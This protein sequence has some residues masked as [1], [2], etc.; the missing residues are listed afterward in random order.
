MLWRVICAHAHMVHAHVHVRTCVMYKSAHA[1]CHVLYRYS[2]LHALCFVARGPAR[3]VCVTSCTIIIKKK[4]NDSKLS[5]ETTLTRHVQATAPVGYTF[6]F[7]YREA[8][9]PMT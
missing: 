9:A 6:S 1:T 2:M 8:T 7:Y 3:E 4:K 5:P